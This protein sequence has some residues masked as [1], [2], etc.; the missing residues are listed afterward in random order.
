[1]RPQILLT[2]FV[3]CIRCGREINSPKFTRRKVCD[4]CKKRSNWYGRKRQPKHCIRCNGTI[5]YVPGT[6]PRQVCGGCIRMMVERY[7]LR[8]C[9]YCDK[10]IGMTKRAL[11]CS[12]R[13]ASNFNGIMHPRGKA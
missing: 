7:A 12:H 11:F 10:K 13:C 3:V 9:I 6:Y 4:A 2:N 8:T 5:P 1:M